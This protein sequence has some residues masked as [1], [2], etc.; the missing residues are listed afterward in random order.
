[1]ATNLTNSDNLGRPNS[2]SVFKI[3]ENGDEPFRFVIHGILFALVLTFG[4]ISNLISMF[5]FTRPEMRTPLNLILTGNRK[6]NNFSLK[7]S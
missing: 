2:I 4:I 5:I 7:N 1:M 3:T 6:L